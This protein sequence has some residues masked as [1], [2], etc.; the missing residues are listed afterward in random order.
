M[1]QCAPIKHI[2][3]YS[4]AKARIVGPNIRADQ[5]KGELSQDLAEQLKQMKSQRE[6]Y[7]QVR[8]F[9]N[10][11]AFKFYKMDKMYKRNKKVSNSD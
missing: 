6:G 3:E 7:Y 1:L 5:I 4:L 8:N 9:E 2:L 10:T 11:L